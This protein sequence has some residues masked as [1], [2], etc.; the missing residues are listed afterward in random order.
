MPA[1]LDSLFHNVVDTTSSPIRVEG[2]GGGEPR[3]GGT[4]RFKKFIWP[5]DINSG[6][7][8]FHVS[9]NEARSMPSLTSQ[10]CGDSL[11]TV[12]L[13]GQVGA[14]YR[15]PEHRCM[16]DRPMNETSVK[17]NH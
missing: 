4:L 7:F 16:P 5:N 15:P 11:L 9:Q 8:R 13:A 14:I 17:V 10:S 6:C 2:G 12:H 3:S 1:I